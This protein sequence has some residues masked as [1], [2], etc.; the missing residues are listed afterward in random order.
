MPSIAYLFWKG[1][2]AEVKGKSYLST[3]THSP[4]FYPINFYFE[5][6]SKLQKLYKEFPYTLHLNCSNINI[7]YSN[8]FIIFFSKYTHFPLN[9][10]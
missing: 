7:F 5:L 9:N 6:I 10:L 8:Y 4:L 1:R 2:R 3:D